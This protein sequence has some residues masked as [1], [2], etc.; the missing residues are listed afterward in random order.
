[1]EFICKIQIENTIK[2]LIWP[3]NPIVAKGYF[4]STNL[5]NGYRII[6]TSLK[7]STVLNSYSYENAYRDLYFDS[8]GSRIIAAGC[9]VSTVDTFDF[10]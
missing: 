4:F 2:H 3:Q 6:K 1:M 8:T 10:D 5:G 9:S 7:S